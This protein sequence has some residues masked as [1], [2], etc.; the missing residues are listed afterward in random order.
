MFTLH[1]EFHGCHA[2]LGQKHFFP[3]ASS[4]QQNAVSNLWY[5]KGSFAP[6]SEEEAGHQMS[7]RVW[8]L[9]KQ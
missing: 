9:T 5:I 4:L 1:T 2:W 8:C 7:V 3:F 6:F